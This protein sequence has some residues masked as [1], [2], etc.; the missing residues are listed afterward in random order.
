MDT[1]RSMRGRKRT[2]AGSA[3]VMATIVISSLM[4]MSLAFLQLGLAS[5]K[6]VAYSESDWAASYLA[7]AAVAEAV[8]AARAGGSGAVGSQAA[9]A[10]LGGGLFWVEAT[11]LGSGQTQLRVMAMSGSGRAGLEVVIENQAPSLM[12]GVIKIDGGIELHTGVLVDSFDSSL[13]TYASQATNVMGHHT[14]ASA[15]APVI[16]NE[17]LDLHTNGGIFGDAIPGP[18]H[19]VSLHTGAFVTGATNPAAEPF[20]LEPIQVPVAASSGNL[21]VG[22]AT[23][24]GPGTLRFGALEIDRDAELTIEGPAEIILEDFVTN[25]DATLVIDATNG[26][27]TVYCT[28]DFDYARDFRTVAATGSPLDLVY[29]ITSNGTISF[30]SQ[31]AIVGGFYAPDASFDFSSHNEVW[32]SIVASELYM[33]SK[34]DFHFDEYLFN[35]KVQTAEAKIAIASWRVAQGSAVPFTAK[36]TDPFELLGVEWS[37]L[38]LPSAAWQP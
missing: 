36:R 5:S 23:S 11:D 18:G 21:T 6:E 31:A 27:V 3:L 12:E 17:E 34:V 19:T 30:P 25:R 38:P 29:M 4:V 15:N 14:Y 13:G 2:R 32:G 33:H 28:G 20:V 22:S 26:P 16:T 10:R 1:G 8:A 35:R 9:P 24:I 7:E 37:D